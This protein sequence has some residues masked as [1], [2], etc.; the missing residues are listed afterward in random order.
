MGNHPQNPISKIQPVWVCSIFHFQ[1]LRLK[2][3]VPLPLNFVMDTTVSE[4]VFMHA[5]S[6]MISNAETIVTDIIAQANLLAGEPFTAQTPVTALSGGQSRALMIADT[7][8]LSSSPVVL[9]DEIENAGIDRKKALS[10]LVRQEKIVLMA[11]HDPILALMAERRLIIKNG[12]I[13]RVIE[14]TVAEKENLIQLEALDN[15]LLALRTRLRSGEL[16]EVV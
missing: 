5:E 8:F 15:K 4:F 3:A 13:H 10:L 16:L 9:I 11:T 7:A 6:R 1:F 12:G 14:T 2:F